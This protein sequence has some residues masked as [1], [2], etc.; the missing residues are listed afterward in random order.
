VKLKLSLVLIV[1]CGLICPAQK[2]EDKAKIGAQQI[3]LKKQILVDD[4]DSQAKNVQFADI[5]IFVRTR[6]AQWLWKD[7]KDET[8]RAE[9]LA[10]KAFE[11]LYEKKDEIAEPHSLRAA[12]FSLLEV[13]AKETAQ[14]LKAKYNVTAAEDLSNAISLLNQK[15]GDK[16]VADKIRKNLSGVKDLAGIELYLHALRRQKSPEFLPILFEIVRLYESGVYNF[17]SA[18]FYWIADNFR[19]SQVPNELKIRYYKIV[20]SKGAAALQTADVGEI[21]FTDLLLFRVLPDMTANAPALAAEASAIKSALSAKVPQGTKDFQEVEQ[22]ISESADKL[23]TLI[24]EADKTDNKSLKYSL[25]DRAS[26]LALEQEKFRLAVDLTERTIEEQFD[27]SSPGKEFRV[28]VHDQ[29][30]MHIMETAL[31]KDVFESADYAGKKIID[32]L[33]KAD[34]LLQ[35]AGY[36]TRKKDSASAFDAFD[37]ALKLTV[38]A[39]NDKAKYTLLLRFINAANSIDRSRLSE[40]TSIA[41]KTINKIPTLNVEDKPGTQKFK[42]YVSTIMTI[43]RY[44]DVVIGNLTR[45]NGNEAVNFTNQI[46]RREI[47]IVADLILAIGMFEPERKQISK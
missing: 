43:D 27:S 8:G 28:S 16:I 22:R 23:E 25:L 31:L 19:D 40:I 33:K 36:F 3:I 7:G 39:E 6:L 18:S 29:Q 9:L 4:L 47:R 10:V 2:A 26:R 32:D 11:E 44:L 45:T 42:D 12:L 38:R 35:F 46:N 5:R 34:A 20:L 41:A 24:S 17:S 1:F 30:L 15:G 13:N 14:R 37:E 21:H